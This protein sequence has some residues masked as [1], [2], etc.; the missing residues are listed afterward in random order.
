ML[1]K[2]D[3]AILN[4]LAKDGRTSMADLGKNLISPHLRFLKGLRS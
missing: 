4:E 1:D 3:N 2:V